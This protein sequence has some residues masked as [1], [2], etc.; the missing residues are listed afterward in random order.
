MAVDT[1]RQGISAALAKTSAK[2]IGA[3]KIFSLIELPPSPE[4]GDYAFPCFLLAKEL[5]KNPKE[6]AE[7]LQKEIKPLNFVEKIEVAGPYLNFFVKK[8]VLAETIIS[9]VLKEKKKFGS[10]KAGKGKKIMVEF[11]HANT[12]KA[13]HVGHIRNISLGESVCRILE[14]TGNKVIRVNYQGDIGLHVAKC[15]FSYMKEKGNVPQTSRG[16]WLSGLYAKAHKLY[17]ENPEIAEEINEINRKIY[18]KDKAVLDAWKKTRK[19]CL[20]AFDAMYRSFNVKFD[21]LYFESEAEAIGKKIVLRELKKGTFL[22]SDGAI[23]ADLKE[24]DLGVAVLL[25]KE[26][27]SLYH[28]KELGLAE[29]KQK[30]YN[31]GQSIHVVGK[32]QELYFRQFFKILEKMGNILGK[33]STHLIYELVMLP[34]GKMSSRTGTVVLYQDLIEKLLSFAEQETR[35][36]H[37]DW[38]AGKKDETARKLSF[39]ALKFS[40]LSVENNKRIVFD[41]EKALDFEGQTAPYVLY[42]LVRCNSIIKKAG[43]QKGKPDFS[44]LK[45][46]DEKELVSLLKDFPQKVSDASQHYSPHIIVH[47]LLSLANNF[48][49][50]YHKIPVLQAESKELVKARLALVKATAQVIQNGLELLGIETLE[51][52]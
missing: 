38:A 36:R 31:F 3:E 14:A 24:S 49:S 6:I 1:F 19:M 17:E 32:E 37:P 51:E 8:H 35:K 34:E 30:E 39:A 5:K 45:E 12:H 21:R 23:I 41:W 10:S 11:F 26:G 52:M 2:G 50:F 18:S 9:A 25:N 27:N 42:A 22:E 33:K 20:D 44:L 43:K 13:V 29:L 28:A 15:L 16:V 46:D 40:M 4:L 48:N 7:Q 47:Y